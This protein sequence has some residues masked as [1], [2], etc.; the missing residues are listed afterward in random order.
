MPEFAP[1]PA[2][3]QVVFSGV[4]ILMIRSVIT[5]MIMIVITTLITHR[6]QR[7][8][9]QLPAGRVEWQAIVLAVLFDG[10]PALSLLLNE[11][12]SVFIPVN[13]GHGLSFK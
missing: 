12:P 11:S 1:V 4:I 5:R 3:G 9:V 6:G 7:F 8:T 10:Y 2:Y 13:F